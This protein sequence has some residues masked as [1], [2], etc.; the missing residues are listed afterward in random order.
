M[1]TYTETFHVAATS[2][3]ITKVRLVVMA[4][5]AKSAVNYWTVAIQ[6]R[7]ADAE[8]GDAVC[9]SFSTATRDL[10]AGEAETMYDSDTGF[11]MFADERLTVTWTS[12]GSPTVPTKPYLLIDRQRI[13][14]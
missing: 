10:T 11:E 13:A 6:R 9:E 8:I 5:L 1:A 14:R 7:V 3:K 4:N 2:Q 12:T